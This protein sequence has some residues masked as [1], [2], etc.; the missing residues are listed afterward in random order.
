MFTHCGKTR[1]CLTHNHCVL[2][3][4]RNGGDLSVS[5][6]EWKKRNTKTYNCRVM[7]ASGIPAAVKK[8]A[9]DHGLSETGVFIAAVKEKLENEGYWKPDKSQDYAG[10]H[11]RIVGI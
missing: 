2:Y 8:Y 7:N 3:N 10:P 4:G 1:K 11:G 5:N 9:E 6:D